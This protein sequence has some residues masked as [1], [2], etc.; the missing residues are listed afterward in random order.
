MFTV[1][2][3]RQL[4]DRLAT[5]ERERGA[6]HLDT[7]AC[8]DELFWHYLESGNRGEAWSVYWRQMKAFGHILGIPYTE[9]REVLSR[10]SVVYA[11]AGN[12]VMAE[13]LY[14]RGAG[15]LPLV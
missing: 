12:F 13:R 14:E 3:D 15:R 4:L 9:E 1:N 11:N 10:M 6:E 8:L 2:N 5:L 7:L